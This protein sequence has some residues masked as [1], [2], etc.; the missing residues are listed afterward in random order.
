[1]IQ[2]PVEYFRFSGLCNFFAFSGM[3]VVV[4]CKQPRSRIA[5]FFSLMMALV[6]FW[7][8]AYYQWLNVLTDPQEALFWAR[9]LMIPVLLLPPVFFGFS[10]VA[11]NWHGRTARVLHTV[12]VMT[13][14]ILVSFVYSNLIAREVRPM[15]TFPFWPLAGVGFH[16]HFAQMLLSSGGGLWIIWRAL[17]INAGRKRQQLT[18]L[19]W[20]FL[21][22][23]LA[24]Y[25][26]YLPWYEG[27]HLYPIL[28]PFS[29]VFTGLAGYAI[30]KHQLLDLRLVIGKSVLYSVIAACI[31]AVYITVVLVTERGFPQ[32]LGFRSISAAALAAFIISIGFIPLKDAIQ[33]LIDQIFMRRSP[34]A[35]VEENEKLRQE[36]ARTERLRAV[37]TLAAGLAHEIKNPLSS[38]KTFAEYLPER[39]EDPAYRKNFSKIVAQEVDKMNG[40]VRRLLDFARPA[41]PKLGRAQLHE[42]ISETVGLLQSRLIERHVEVTVRMGPG[43]NGV[44]VDPVQIKQALLNLLLNSIEALNGAGQIEIETRLAGQ[45]VE[46][47]I[48][49]NGRGIPKENLQ[50]VFD[51]FFTTRDG[52]TGL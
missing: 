30:V 42:L 15:L 14:F 50:R 19:F 20:A 5:Q 1:M 6:A 27:I 24:A 16:L 31:T 3:G 48:S 26:N 38:I 51:P 25:G 21:V 49:D 36:L 7:G 44:W 11:A 22:A 12:N 33:R 40:L 41:Q 8:W 29:A 17:S 4:L 35:L 45:G 34:S 2:I 32:F 47:T 18:W 13:A 43:V 52:G 10:A 46:L 28:T 37:G 39:Y 23:Y 9:T